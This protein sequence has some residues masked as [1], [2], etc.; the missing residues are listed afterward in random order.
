MPRVRAEVAGEHCCNHSMADST[1]GS[2]TT[3]STFH[4]A[5][6]FQAGVENGWIPEHTIPCRGGPLRPPVV[7]HYF[8]LAGWMSRVFAEVAGER[9]CNHLMAGTAFGSRTTRSTFHPAARFQAG[10]ENGWIPEHKF[11]CR[12]GPLRPPVLGELTSM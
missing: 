8:P 1:F 5:A 7:T 6:R 10:V 11:P 2:R 3:R 9:W 12:G 4:P